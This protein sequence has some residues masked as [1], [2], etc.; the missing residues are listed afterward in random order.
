MTGSL[1]LLLLVLA[2]AIAV[3]ALRP[4]PAA[5]GVA[6]A[7]YVAPDA[8]SR[9]RGLGFDGVTS[10]D[11]RV[12][13]DAV[14]AARPEARRLVAAVAGLVTVRVAGVQPSVAGSASPTRTGYD[15]VLDLGQVNRDLGTRGVQR[16][17]L[18]ELGHVVDFAL[19]PDAVMAGLDAGIPAG[20][21]CE[22]GRLGSCAPG[23]ERF[24]ES[25]AKWAMDDIGVD[26]ELGYK[27]PPPALA[28][29][30]WGRPLAVLAR[31]Q[32]GGN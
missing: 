19:V 1:R 24:A 32:P 31:G 22:D 6:V 10:G 11:Q 5:P 28:L 18:H 2:G 26:L 21:G 17:V 12:V 14:S 13:L 29:S 23:E 4:A 25:F 16:L 20:Y 15:L 27:V 3:W 8:A 7:A 30:E 9:G